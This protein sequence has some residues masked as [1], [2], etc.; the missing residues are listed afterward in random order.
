MPVNSFSVPTVVDVP[1]IPIKN[2]NV[3]IAASDVGLCD[4]KWSEILSLLNGRV[5]LFISFV[6][7]LR[8]VQNTSAL[9]TSDLTAGTLDVYDDVATAYLGTVGS[10]SLGYPVVPLS[11]TQDVTV[12]SLPL[13]T[14]TAVSTYFISPADAQLH[15]DL[16]GGTAARDGFKLV[17]MDIVCRCWFF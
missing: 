12:V 10:F 3:D 9:G 15:L 6:V 11:T 1:L 2:R 17:E 5:P 7:T 4:F 13:G 8:R 16:H 14:P